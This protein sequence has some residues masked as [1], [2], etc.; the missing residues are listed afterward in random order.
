MTPP[1]PGCGAG[2][3]V[4]V[5]RRHFGE[6][7]R[8]AEI[9]PVAHCWRALGIAV[10]AALLF[11]WSSAEAKADSV[12]L[13]SDPWCPYVCD[14]GPDRPGYLV[15]IV[16]RTLSAAGHTVVF[17]FLPWPR[18]IAAVR[19]GT[20][21]AL[22][23][24]GN[25]DAP[26]LVMTKSLGRMVTALAIRRGSGFRYDGVKSLE[27][28]RLATAAGVG[29]WG[30]GIDEYIAANVGNPDRI[31]V[32]PGVDPYAANLRKLVA[33]RVDVVVDNGH[34]LRWLA[35][36]L[37]LSDKIEIVAIAESDDI[38]I[39]FSPALPNSREYVQQ[40]ENGVERLRASGELAAIMARYGMEDWQK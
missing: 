19:S 28:L 34:V 9:V 32:T 1:Q 38:R 37:N 25:V 13:A 20:V 10:G 30:G 8:L 6:A 35:G 2:K 4:A 27:H 21:A 17:R 26:D 40:V 31:D 11:V 7:R 36:R 15:E 39:G 16:E 24:M 18:A 33:G 14:G 12:V 5:G 22:V 29:S 3:E 23:G